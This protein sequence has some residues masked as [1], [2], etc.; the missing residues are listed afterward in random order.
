MTKEQIL[1][2]LKQQ[3]LTLRDNDPAFKDQMYKLDWSEKT[4]LLT[5]EIKKMNSCDMLWLDEKYGEFFK[6]E[7]QPRIKK[8]K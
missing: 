6:K 5:K 3:I 1:E 7:I 2:L 4:N 8:T